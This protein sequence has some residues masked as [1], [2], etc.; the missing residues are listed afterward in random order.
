MYRRFLVALLFAVL[1]ACGGTVTNP[2]QNV[3]ESFPG[4][5]DPAVNGGNGPH[6]TFTAANNGEVDIVF[7]ALSPAAFAIVTFGQFA[8]NQCI[9]I[10]QQVGSVGQA[11]F[12]S[13]INQGSY[14]LVVSVYPG[15]TVP[16]T[17]TLKVSHP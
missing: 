12:A 7:T 11:V 3:T 15:I 14:C 17:Y 6:I 1:A 5:V 8:Q 10:A 13:S 4:A 16:F 9:P 2:S